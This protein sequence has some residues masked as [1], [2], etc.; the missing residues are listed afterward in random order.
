MGSWVSVRAR[1]QSPGGEG[2]GHRLQEGGG[3]LQ[4]RCWAPFHTHAF[5][6]A[7]YCFIIVFAHTQSRHFL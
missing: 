2:M 3:G 7:D 1:A 6:C 4:V 5:A